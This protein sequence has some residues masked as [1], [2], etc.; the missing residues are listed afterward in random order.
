VT[1]RSPKALHEALDLLIAQY[2]LA[3]P[4]AMPSKTTLLQLMQWNHG[5]IE[6]GEG[7]PTIEEQ[8]APLAA[9]RAA[10]KKAGFDV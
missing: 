1:D 4:K 10:A 9:V 8:L 3:H 2:L 6:R 7:E 5:R